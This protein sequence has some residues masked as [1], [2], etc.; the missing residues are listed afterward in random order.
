[1]ISLEGEKSSTLLYCWKFASNDCDLLLDDYTTCTFNH[2]SN[3]AYQGIGNEAFLHSR[4]PLHAVVEN[5]NVI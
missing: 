1:M 2:S 3:V 5:A 4:L